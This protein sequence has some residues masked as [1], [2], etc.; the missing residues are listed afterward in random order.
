M[1]ADISGSSPLYKN[2]GD[3]KANAFVQQLLSMM[4]DVTNKH[5]DKVIKTIGDEVMTCFDRTDGAVRRNC[6]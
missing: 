6:K 4:T 2:L 1:F 3:A 5:H